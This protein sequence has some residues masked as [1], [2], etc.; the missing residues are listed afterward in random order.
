MANQRWGAISGGDGS[1][2]NRCNLH[3]REVHRLA[4]AEVEHQ[5]LGCE[6]DD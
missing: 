6:V 1:D 2:G 3:P 4:V 5:M